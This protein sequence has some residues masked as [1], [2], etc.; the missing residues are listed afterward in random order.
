MLF[1]DLDG[2][3]ALNDQHG[4]QFGDEVLRQVADRLR[5]VFRN[6]DTVAR[7]GGDEFAV[8]LPRVRSQSHLAA[9]A[10]RAQKAFAQPF[11][12]EEQPV[13]LGASVGRALAP[14]HGTTID[15]LV[16][17]ADTAMYEL[18]AQGRAAPVATQ[19]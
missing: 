4:H 8:I 12:I 19:A 3:K 9:A 5:G 10:K 11:V 2:F 6:E 15:E 17:H 1:V 7:V 13:S 14:E 18:K 16:R